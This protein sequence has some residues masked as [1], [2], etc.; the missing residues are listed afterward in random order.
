MLCNFWGC[1]LRGL[2]L[3]PSFFG[4][5]SWKPNTMY[6]VWP[7]CNEEVQGC[8]V[9]RNSPWKGALRCQ[10]VSKGFL[11]FPVHPNHQ[12]NVAEWITPP[13]AHGTKEPPSWALSRF[14]IHTLKSKL[15]RN[16][17]KPISFGVCCYIS[18]DNQ[19]TDPW[20]TA[21]DELCFLK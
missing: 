8:Q 14:L 16:S 21:C 7:P 6:K 18:V 19:N 20:I 17:F 11:H 3:L 10:H 15:D 4:A 9:V 13:M 5:L 12:L 1:T 2:Q